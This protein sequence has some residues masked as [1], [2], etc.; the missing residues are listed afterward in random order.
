MDG[1][2][3]AVEMSMA[4]ST[5]GRN[6]HTAELGPCFPDDRAR[7]ALLE[8]AAALVAESHRLEAAGGQLAVALRPL[9]LTLN[10]QSSGVLD[11]CSLR[12]SEIEQAAAGHYDEDPGRARAQSLARAHIIAE[13]VLSAA[14]PT[15]RVGLY[16]PEFVQCIH[17]ELHR[18][19]V[20]AELGEE[21]R[22]SEASSDGPSSDVA[23]APLGVSDA[24][25]A[26]APDMD[27]LVGLAARAANE[28]PDS[29]ETPFELTEPGGWRLLPALARDAA[30]AELIP[31]LCDT[32]QGVYSVPLGLEQ[33]LV[34]AFCAERRLLWLRPFAHGNRRTAHLHTQLVLTA[35]GATHGL[36]SPLRGMGR[37]RDG[38][39]ALVQ[40]PRGDAPRAARH[41]SERDELDRYSTWMLDICLAEARAARDLLDTERL[42]GRLGDLLAWLGAR[43]WTMGSEKSV[44]KPDALE[45]LHYAAITGP[46]ERA[47]FIA[48]LGL[49]HRTGRRVL[50][51]LID[52]GLLVSESS[53]AP[54][55]FNLPPASLRFLLPG[56]WPEA[57]SEEPMSA[58]GWPQALTSSSSQESAAE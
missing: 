33:A 9:V 27:L 16:A 17:A 40:Q 21:T 42:K 52:F 41:A 1:P 13:S 5:D 34:A 23:G 6:S 53:R 32:W 28:N 43:P 51:S 47:R 54:V 20:S 7:G 2:N 38:Y 39:H 55:R 50:S 31:E 46:V 44:I 29:D 15:K 18:A 12:P 26:A 11:G 58:S 3:S 10:A 24:A 49:Q 45:A 30:P 35:L 8:R 25:P 48:M 14:L 22:V 36:W 57:G 56:F 4:A 19:I 37:D